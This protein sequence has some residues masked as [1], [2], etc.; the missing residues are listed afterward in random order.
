MKSSTSLLFL[1]VGW[2]ASGASYAGAANELRDAQRIVVIT[3]DEGIHYA[4]FCAFYELRDLVSE[5]VGNDVISLDGA[6]H[7]LYEIRVLGKFGERVVYIGDHWI[8]TAENTAL[9][10]IVDFGR[11]VDLIEKRRGQGV[12]PAKVDLSV[13]RALSQIQDLAYVEENR[14]RTRDE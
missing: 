6:A 5:S 10:P 8:K 12:S 11:I 14:C 4:Q 13:K 1:V 2:L 9:I 7:R 3:D